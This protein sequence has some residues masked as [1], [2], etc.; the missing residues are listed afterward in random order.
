MIGSYC[1][2]TGRFFQ[3]RNMFYAE[4]FFFLVLNVTGM[5]GFSSCSRDFVRSLRSFK[6]ICSAIF[7]FRCLWLTCEFLLLN[8]GKHIRLHTRVYRKARNK[9]YFF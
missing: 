4:F 5:T 7:V 6:A 8:L 2:R 9:I 3:T 1:I